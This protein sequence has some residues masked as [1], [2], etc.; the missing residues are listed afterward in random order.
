MIEKVAAAQLGGFRATAIGGCWDNGPK[1][2]TFQ[3]ERVEPW[4]FG[5]ELWM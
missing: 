2:Q 1:P 5:G 4:R 3:V